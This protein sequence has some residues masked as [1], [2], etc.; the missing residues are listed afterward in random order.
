ME[1]NS[2]LTSEPVLPADPVNLPPLDVPTRLTNRG[3]LPGPAAPAAPTG[4]AAMRVGDREVELYWD[5]AS[6]VSQ[7]GP[8]SYSL[9]TGSGGSPTLVA[10]VG[11]SRHTWTLTKLTPGTSY[12]I[13][14]TAVGPGGESALSTALVVTTLAAQTVPAIPP[15]SATGLVEITGAADGVLSLRWNA[16]GATPPVTSYKVL[17]GITVKTTVNAPTTTGT[18]NVP[19][20][21][22]FA[23]TVRAVNSAGDGPPSNP[24]LTG[25]MPGATTV[26]AKITGLALNGAATTTTVP[27]QWTADPKASSYK[28]YD[29]GTLKATVPAPATSTTLTGYTTGTAYSITVK[30]SNAVGDGAASNALTGSTA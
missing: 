17:D 8:L 21:A 18:V 24:A 1:T 15:N 7:W 4:L 16:V 20:G 10:Q 25:V 6:G 3:T 12:T 5:A 26:P 23:V 28:V 11:G 14:V 22:A 27:I 19:P 9:Y 29:G 2:D 30:G 13:R